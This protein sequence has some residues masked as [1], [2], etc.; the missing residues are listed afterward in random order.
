MWS[1]SYGAL[2]LLEYTLLLEATQ[3]V[4]VTHAACLPRRECCGAGH[5]AP[6]AAAAAAPAA[7][8]PV[9]VLTL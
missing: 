6:P 8:A 1:C 7:R 5:A 4:T 3:T 9:S 2:V